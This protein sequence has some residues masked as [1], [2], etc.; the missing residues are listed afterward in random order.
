MRTLQPVFGHS[1]RV[2]AL[3]VCFPQNYNKPA[4]ELP[5]PVWCGPGLQSAVPGSPPSRT[6]VSVVFPLRYI[7]PAQNP[8][9]TITPNLSFIGYNPRKCYENAAPVLPLGG[10]PGRLRL[11]PYQCNPA[12]TKGL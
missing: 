10:T 7:S 4:L 8:C 2:P 6:T 12:A 5:R 1:L 3:R 11:E 9:G